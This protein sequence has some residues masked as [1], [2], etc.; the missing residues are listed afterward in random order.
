MGDERARRRRRWS[1]A[2]I[3]RAE[4]LALAADAIEPTAELEGLRA[5][6]AHVPQISIASPWAGAL[7][8][9]GIGV[10]GDWSR[11]LDAAAEAVPGEPSP[12]AAVRRDAPFQLPVELGVAGLAA[13]AVRPQRTLGPFEGIAGRYWIDLFDH[14]DSYALFESGSPRPVLVLT[15]ASLPLFRTIGSY[16]VEIDG[17]TVWIAAAALDPAAAPTDYVG[18][19]VSGGTLVLTAVP[20]VSGTRLTTSGA[21]HG[22]LELTLA[23]PGGA[24]PGAGDCPAQATVRPPASLRV[25]W[26]GSSTPNVRLDGPATASFAGSTFTFDAFGSPQLDRA[27]N[28]IAFPA[29]PQPPSLD[30]APLSSDVVK[31]DGASAVTGG[32]GLTLAR[33]RDPEHPGEA[34]DAGFA[35]LRPQQSLHASWAGSPEPAELP[36]AYLSVREGQVLLFCQHARMP[37]DGVQAMPLYAPRSTPDADQPPPRLPLR[38]RCGRDFTFGYVCDRAQGE[39]LYA[40]C[41]VELRLDRPVDVAGRTL[42][43]GRVPLALLSV[44]RAGGRPTVSLKGLLPVAGEHAPLRPRRVLA[45]RNALLAVSEPALFRLEGSFSPAGSVDAGRLQLTLAGFGWLPTLPDPYVTNFAPGSRRAFAGQAQPDL[46]VADTSWD[47]PSAP[48]LSFAGTLRPPL[49]VVERAEPGPARAA[50][51]VEEPQL[52]T[53][54]SQGSS[55]LS[56][57][58]ADFPAASRAS[59]FS[60][61]TTTTPG[62][63]EAVFQRLA[64]ETLPQFGTGL[65]LLDIS[66]NLD[67]LGVEHE[68]IDDPRGYALSGLDV[69]LPG[70]SLTVFMPPQVLWE[71]V[72]TLDV[73]QDIPK[74]GYFPTP[75]ASATDGGPTA[76][77]THSGRLVPA[78]PDRAV[79]AALHAF[80]QEGAGLGVLTTLPF[81]V[82]ALLRLRPAPTPDGRRPDVV[83]PNEPAFDALG[84]RGGAQL[85]L[86]AESGPSGRAQSSSF[87]GAALQLR[88]GVT[89]ASGAPLH[90]DVL[91]STASPDDSVDQFFNRQFGPG[92]P[93]ACVPVTRLDLSGYGG[94][95]FSDWADANA[96]FAEAAKV[97]FNV[98][99]GRAALED[100]KLASVLYPGCVRMTR[101]L[102]IERRGGGGLIRRDSGWQPSSNGLFQVPP[103]S[104]GTPYVVQPGLLRGFFNVRNVRPSGGA[105]VRFRTVGGLD[106]LL[107]PKLFDAD[108][109]IAGLVGADHLVATGMLGFLQVQPRG[110]ALHEHDLAA[111][112][113]QQGPIGGP[114]DGVV[115]LGNSGFRMRATRVEVGVAHSGAHPEL[116]GTVRGAPLFRQDGAWS[117]LRLPGPGNPQ[118]DGDAVG[119]EQVRGLPVVREGR[120]N[121]V[122]DETMEIDLAGEYRFADAADLHEPDTPQFEYGFAQ[123]SPAHAFLFPRPYFAEG[124]GE[125]RSRPG[126]RFADIYARAT[127][128]GAFPPAGNAI[129]LPPNALRVDP[130]TGSFRLRDAVDVS[131]PRGPLVLAT[132]G[133]DVVQVD[134][135]GARLRTSVGAAD[136]H[137]E[138][139]DVA[140]WTDLLGISRFT[141]WSSDLVAGTGQ[142]PLLQK[143]E[144]LFGAELADAVRFLRALD[145]RPPLPP[146]DLSATNGINEVEIA[147]AVDYHYEFEVPLFGV[148]AKV[149]VALGAKGHL[150]WEHHPAPTPTP[151]M[152]TAPTVETSGGA[153]V[154]GEIEL[155]LPLGGGWFAVVGAEL[156][157]GA[158][159]RIAVSAVV[160]PGVIPPPLPPPGPA[161]VFELDFKAYIGIGYGG[162]VLGFGAE[163]SVAIGADVAIEAAE[164]TVQPFLTLKAEVRFTEAISVEIA[165][166]FQGK[167]H[168]AP[169]GGHDLD[170]AGEVEL[171]IEICWFGIHLGG[172]IH[173]TNHL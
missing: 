157:A 43:I 127:S 130:A 54:T 33:P 64:R 52:P 96:A 23:N 104:P 168:D 158:R 41:S 146:I 90:L 11:Y 42:G 9:A 142:R 113:D 81:G 73:D 118:G 155:Q 72:R 70:S 133:T 153:L 94:S 136:W 83:Q 143:L 24:D 163:G 28:A 156:E 6:L 79:T 110:V 95:T 135:A 126:P 151:D 101:T 40:T 27:V 119:V 14:V 48:R 99:L 34:L 3:E 97:Q 128:K 45:V 103:G 123:T 69:C 15:Q 107:V 29:D 10:G 84:L 68:P 120:L 20:V 49:A 56:T 35:L 25:S 138:L 58:R 106:A 62:Y 8:A 140:L 85:T 161:L 75:L 55:R 66:T 144:T 82:K 26:S 74:L 108:V 44:A 139:T 125:L 71:P 148:R 91:A 132:N 122:A 129:Q 100:V 171:N 167:L 145:T 18:I 19:T 169:G 77:G 1:R 4:R 154:T 51:P 30:V 12:V 98:V 78:R 89:L 93:D 46:V 5:L 16:D 86:V 47:E 117:A 166:E 57:E 53:Q 114:V 87:D 116:V 159:F 162:R 36:H 170:W 115:A 80:E 102:T 7:K 173:G 111:L 141:G 137:V 92:S 172:E 160:P 13:S 134:Y 76:L 112:I 105:P 61:T 164:V 67:L 31:L 131:A 2:E 165:G 38:L 39:V 63:Q 32:W 65:R 124:T 50:P 147:L 60:E 152:P 37:H 149:K 22:T 88:N 150:G 21:L 109:R 59:G 17:G 121:S